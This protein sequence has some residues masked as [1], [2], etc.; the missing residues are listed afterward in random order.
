MVVG[1]I[2]G[3]NFRLKDQV[4]GRTPNLAARLQSEAEADTIVVTSETR[5]LAGEEFVYSDLGLRAMKGIASS[6]RL[7]RV[8]GFRLRGPAKHFLNWDTPIFGRIAQL[9][10]L[11][12]LWDELKRGE[13]RSVLVQGD[14]G[15]GKSRLVSE[16]LTHAEPGR[17]SVLLEFQC[18]PFHSHEPLFPVLDQLRRS[19]I[20]QGNVGSSGPFQTLVADARQERGR[21][22]GPCTPLR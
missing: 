4:V 19:I 17:N 1:D 9:N 18:S 10:A 22:P 7:W 6:V 13:L 21:R 16:V 20:P 8:D 3:D 11:M 14:P 15:I 2:Q 5:A 12:R